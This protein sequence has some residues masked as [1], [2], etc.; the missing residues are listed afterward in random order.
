MPADSA[1]VPATAMCVPAA[2]RTEKVEKLVCNPR[3]HYCQL[4]FSQPFALSSTC[5]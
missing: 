4:A 3:R 2:Y 5:I 1:S